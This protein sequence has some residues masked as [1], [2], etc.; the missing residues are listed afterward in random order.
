LES[1][2]NAGFCPE[3]RSK[4]VKLQYTPLRKGYSVARS[5]AIPGRRSR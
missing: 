2:E 5:S 1:P 3:V 4:S